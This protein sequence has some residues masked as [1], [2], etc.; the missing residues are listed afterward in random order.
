MRPLYCH[1]HNLISSCMQTFRR[2]LDISSIPQ[3]CSCTTPPCWYYFNFHH[4]PFLSIHI[5]ACYYYTYQC[6]RNFTRSYPPHPQTEPVL[7]SLS[8]L[9][10]LFSFRLFSSPSSSPVA[11]YYHHQISQRHCLY[12]G[13]DWRKRTFYRLVYLPTLRQA[14]N[15]DFSHSPRKRTNFRTKKERRKIYYFFIFPARFP[16]HLLISVF[17]SP[18]R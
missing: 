4:S 11:Y 1:N 6:S 9:S 3:L 17:H 2:R 5:V 15:R 16:P 12:S 10:N 18:F 14:A 7:S 13:I 8:C